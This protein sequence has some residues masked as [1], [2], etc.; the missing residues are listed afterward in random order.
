MH[1]F[2]FLTLLILGILFFS[3]GS[4]S[5]KK[6]SY[7]KLKTLENKS[8][9]QLGDTIE[10]SVD[11]SKDREIDSIRLYF[12]E[13]YL[14]TLKSETGFSFS[15]AKNA[16]LGRQKLEA[17]IYAEGKVDTINEHLKIY[18]DTAPKAYSYK[19]IN[20][21]PHSNLAYTQGLEFHNDTLYE[22]TGHYGSS[23]L[24]KLDLESGEVLEK[25]NLDDSYFGEGLTILNNKLYQL[26]WREKTG[27][28]YDLDTFK[29]IGTFSYNQSEE[30]WGLCNDGE[31]LYKSDGTEK[32]WILDAE[33]QAEK[34]YFQVVTNT[35][36]YSKFNELEWVEGK[37]YANT[38]QFPSVSIINP[39]NGAIEAVIDFRGLQDR[40]TNID[41]L[42]PQNDVLNGIAYNPNTK[43][44]Y[45]T[46]KNWDK[47]FEVE[48]IKK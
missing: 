41:D 25:I 7:F 40:L 17:I 29:Q 4:N 35:K 22:S 6:S 27:L 43:K 26:T 20:E 47:L 45:V 5:E 46:G 13:N 30:G 23:S 18:N 19:V 16:R 28:I 33:T 31:K 24:R 44:L 10:A 36:I 39:K 9:F 8:G 3:C 48:I 14:K 34:E 12:Q 21:Y 2:K 42:D 38:Y 37:I 32:I 11:N 1:K 15:V